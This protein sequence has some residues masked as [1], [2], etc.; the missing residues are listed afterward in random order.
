MARTCILVLGMPVSSTSAF[1]HMLNVAGAAVPREAMPTR[2]ED[3]HDLG[4]AQTI[5]G[6]ND[7]LLQKLHSRWD[8]WRAIAPD[9]HLAAVY[10][11]F[12]TPIAETIRAE[13]DNADLIV[14]DDPRISRL[15][16]LYIRV[17][18]R[19]GYQVVFFHALHDPRSVAASLATRDSLGAK[20]AALLWMRYQ[21]DA[22]IAT[23]GQRRGFFTYEDLL[24]DWR[25]V[26]GGAATLLS[27]PSPDLESV[28]ARALDALVS[29]EH[30]HAD[31]APAAEWPDDMSEDIDEVGAFFEKL[32]LDP[33]DPDAQLGLDQARQGL[34]K[35]SRWADRVHYATTAGLRTGDD[36]QHDGVAAAISGGK[37][38]PADIRTRPVAEEDRA[39]IGQARLQS[40]TARLQ[41]SREK[42]ATAKSEL[43]RTSAK[44]Q[45]AL[46]IA[47]AM[48]TEL[49]HARRHPF[50]LIRRLIKY[51]SLRLLAKDASPLPSAMKRRFAKSAAK[52]N[53]SRS[54]LGDYLTGQGATALPLARDVDINQKK[55]AF[56]AEAERGLSKFL[57]SNERIDFFPVSEPKVSIILVLWNQ[58]GLTLNCLRSLES[59]YDVPI[60]I[61]VVDNCSTDRTRELLE[62][63][64]NVRLL[65]QKENL[66]F[67]AGVNRGLEA[68]SGGHVLLL[69]ND[70]TLRPGCLAAACEAMESSPEIGAV[71]GPIVLP[72]GT[73]QEAGSIIWADGSCLGY[74]RGDNPQAGP[75]NFRRE[76]DYC[77]GAFLLVREGL[78][79]ELGGFDTDFAPA[80]YEEADLCMRIW[81]NGKKVV[82]EPRAIIDHFEFASSEKVEQALEL[83][84]TNRRKFVAKH[85]DQ[86]AAHLKPMPDNIIEARS[87][88]RRERI[89]FIE[90]RVPLI[91][92]GS[93]LPRS[94]EILRLM[95]EEGYFVTFFPSNTP[96]ETWEDAWSAVPIEVEVAMGWGLPGL[97]QFL[98]QRK[99]Y[100]QQ[101]FVSRPHNMKALA[102]ILTARPELFEGIRVTYD[103]EAFF[104]T[105]DAIKAE[106]FG[107]TK[108]AEKATQN[109]VSELALIAMA[110][111]VTAVTQSEADQFAEASGKPVHVLSFP[112][113]P[114]PTPAMFNSREDILF[115]GR[116]AEEDTPN[117]DSVLWY[118]DHVQPLLRDRYS[119]EL[120]LTV[121]G[122]T[123][124]PSIL[125]LDP[126]KVRT[127]GIVDDLLPVFDR[128]RVFVAPTRYAAGIPLKVQQAAAYGVPVVATSLLARQLGWN[129]EEDLLVGDT[130]EAFAQAV[131]RLYA[132]SA[133]WERIRS[134]AMKRIIADCSHD[135]FRATLRETLGPHRRPA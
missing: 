81:R 129:D 38:Q 57:A 94:N 79:Q 32:V 77:S 8:D 100:Y 10:D 33:S 23:R 28:P 95:C 113:A 105:R 70:A 78:F 85:S 66:G 35:F 102:K 107:D 54:T 17:L 1:T 21:L 124:A 4:T 44:L 58:A 122:N 40:M 75:Y 62:R 76:V 45:D 133:L 19:L 48:D 127:R 64:D 123:R 31:T 60:E 98:E 135:R 117:V 132:D 7:K 27:L 22:E 69:N 130:P 112:I 39:S 89:L 84:K 49:Q 59:E 97:E 74:G 121:V 111:Q 12:E 118:V 61:I 106:I 43:T 46:R 104:S 93:G 36:R 91:S 5:A 16:P 3:A 42:E 25:S 29:R 116:L 128:A 18:N 52:V 51:R 9:R 20:Q 24:Q 119:L 115:V 63:V 15:V 30:H 120:P 125:S 55:A 71:G 103:A 6:V 53:P 80:Y 34:D 72:D 134:N 26:I 87:P 73:L 110:D 90:D 13:F 108:L 99:G 109:R 131:D 86:L 114:E 83:Q 101:I 92:Q 14:L 126:S 96:T 67:L 68:V 88:D 50:K 2:L 82:F 56:R 65:P 37:S 41:V 47:Q 11:E